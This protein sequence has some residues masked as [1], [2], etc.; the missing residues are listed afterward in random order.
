MAFECT[1]SA[2]SERKKVNSDADVYT[3]RRRAGAVAVKAS[4]HVI[5]FLLSYM[6]LI[7]YNK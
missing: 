1:I 6:L 4:S 2:R 3:A 7:I 5:K